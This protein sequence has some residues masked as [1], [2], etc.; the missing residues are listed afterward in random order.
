MLGWATTSGYRS[1][2]N[3]ARWRDHLDNLL[4]APSK[5]RVVKHHAALPYVE[6][7]ALMADLRARDGV[8]ARALEFLALTCVR[9]SDVL[10]ARHG[11]IDL[12]KRVW[13]IP[14]VSKTFREHRVPLSDAAVAAVERARSQAH[15]KSAYVFANDVTGQRLSKNAPGKLLV[16]MGRQGQLT[17][18]GLRSSFRTWALERT[19]YPWEL[20]ELALGHTVGTAVER[21]YQRGDALK[22]RVAMMQAWADFCAKP[23]QPGKLIPLHR[24]AGA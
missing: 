3:P 5:V 16:R 22:K 7:P 11:D 6:M 19:G 17:P 20:A 4:A 1:G 8:A 14:A 15:G 23:R 10:N 13:T 9:L 2:D 24:K 21:A 18:H 12:A